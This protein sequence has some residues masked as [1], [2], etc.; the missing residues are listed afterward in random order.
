MQTRKI[1]GKDYIQFLLGSQRS[2]SALEGEKVHPSEELSH[3]SITRLLQRGEDTAEELWEEAYEY[4]IGQ[5]GVLIVDD[6]TL[7]K[8]YSK[9]IEPVCWHW[10]GKHHEV[11]KG[12]NVVSLLWSDGDNHI[13]CDFGVFEKDI[14]TKN[15]IFLE[16]IL[17]ARARGVVPEYVLFDSW[18][19]SSENL[20]II[21]KDCG[22]LFLTRLK[23]N[24]LVRF[25]EN[26][27]Y[28]SISDLSEG[29]HQVW[30][31]NFGYIKMFVV[32]QDNKTS[33]WATNN[34]AM[35]ELT[36]LKYSDAGWKIE[37]YHRGIKQFCGVEKC[38]H[39]SLVAQT[40]HIGLAL[41]A[42]LRLER[43]SFRTGISWMNAKLDIVRSA[44]KAYW[45]NPS[46]VF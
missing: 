45:A 31:K 46:I 20:R 36:R 18:Y 11:V 12:I 17:K 27:K 14:K 26:N 22:W 6:S 21:G 39:R 25:S 8:P 23:S 15:Q 42:F 2:V 13:P 33:Y 4:V 3:D 16:L 35:D 10:S 24:R 29:E 40:T 19:S 30:L 32:I 44:V 41:R 38:H 5:K 43:Y 1:T 28:I 7:D 34:L 9:S 37:E